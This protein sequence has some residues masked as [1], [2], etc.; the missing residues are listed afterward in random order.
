MK[1]GSTS[2]VGAGRNAVR[3]SGSAMTRKGAVQL[4]VVMVMVMLV[5]VVVLLAANP[6]SG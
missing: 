1:T 4:S 5:V 3:T 2:K 6:G